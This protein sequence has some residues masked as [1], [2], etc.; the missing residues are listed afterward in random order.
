MAMRADHA[1]AQLAFVARHQLDRTAEVLTE[2]ATETVTN[3]HERLNDPDELALSLKK[4]KKS[5][6]R[7]F[8]LGKVQDSAKRL[9]AL[10]NP[11][12]SEDGLRP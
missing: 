9:F 2:S 10:G 8:Y 11:K 7:R 1:V 12:S 4:R 3:A 5:W 6:H